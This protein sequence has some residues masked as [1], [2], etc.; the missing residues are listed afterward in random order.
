[1]QII[2]IHLLGARRES[3]N[4]GAKKKKGAY[5]PMFLISNYVSLLLGY[6]TPLPMDVVFISKK[7][8]SGLAF[9]SFLIFFSFYSSIDS[10][11]M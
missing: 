10:R 8:M 3:H 5:S 7:V 2:I 1:M 6:L 11:N 4:K 9:S